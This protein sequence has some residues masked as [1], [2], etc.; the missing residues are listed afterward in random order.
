MEQAWMNAVHGGLLIGLAAAL[1][2][3]LNGRILGVSGIVHRI[4]AWNKN[5]TLWRILFF[6]GIAAGGAIASQF[7]P[8]HFATISRELRFGRVFAGG[9]LVG[10]GTKLGGGCTSGHGICGV[11]RISPRGIV[12]TCTFIL[13]GMLT[14][15]IMGR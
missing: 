13:F 3:V 2:L 11:G 6:V 14:V 4:Y 10:F 12:A 9:L 5:D 7:W 15:F 1:M 8:E